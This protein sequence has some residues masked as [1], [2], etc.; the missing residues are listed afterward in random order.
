MPQA[1]TKPQANSQ[2]QPRHLSWK[3]IAREAMTPLITRQYVSGANSTVA[4]FEL[5]AG[6][7]VPEHAHENEQICVVTAGALK[8]TMS[9]ADY[10][11]RAGELLV[12]PPNIPHRA[13][14]VERT[15]CFDF[16]SPPRADWAANNDAYLRAGK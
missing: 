7:V 4:H 5:Q 13:E 12:I 10:V 15:I 8:F 3:N 6:S 14:A 11:I 1:E 9:G 16:F 2:S